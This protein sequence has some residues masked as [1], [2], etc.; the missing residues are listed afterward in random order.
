[1]YLCIMKL[2]KI[3]FNI[4]F[5]GNSISHNNQVFGTTKLKKR[6]KISTFRLKRKKKREEDCVKNNNERCLS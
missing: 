2:H 6:K 1:M 4:A 3:G 5:D